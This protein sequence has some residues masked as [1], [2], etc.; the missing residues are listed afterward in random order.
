MMDERLGLKDN[1]SNEGKMKEAEARLQSNES[2]GGKNE[3][4]G[5]AGN[6]AWLLGLGLSLLPSNHL[7]LS[8]RWQ[9]WFLRLLFFKESEQQLVFRGQSGLL[10]LSCFYTI[11]CMGP[12]G[13]YVLTNIVQVGKCIVNEKN[14]VKN[15]GCLLP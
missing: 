10:L 7:D 11:V 3:K 15:L 13:L 2:E 14:C 9:Q 6:L 5:D 8:P 4:L 12:I 1:M